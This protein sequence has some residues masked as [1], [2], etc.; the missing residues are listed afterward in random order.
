[1]LLRVALAL[2]PNIRTLAGDMQKSL[3]LLVEP[4]TFM[5]K[6]VLNQLSLGQSNPEIGISLY[7]AESTVKSYLLNV[8]DKLG[9]KSRLEAVLTAQA[10]GLVN[11]P[12]QISPEALAIL[13]I[14]KAYPGTVAKL[15]EMG[16][17]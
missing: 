9:V 17:F 13:A 15:L 8:F 5:E 7:L 14:E 11:V 6:Q 16:A 3:I 2:K 10:L 12:D 1:M 4:L